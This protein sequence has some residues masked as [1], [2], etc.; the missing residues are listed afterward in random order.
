MSN[1]ENVI[2]GRIREAESA[3]VHRDWFGRAACSAPQTPPVTGWLGF[4]ARA[5]LEHLRQKSGRLG[6][7]LSL[8]SLS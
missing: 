6:R 2:D 1:C 7:F 4:I 8:S 5:H 3:A